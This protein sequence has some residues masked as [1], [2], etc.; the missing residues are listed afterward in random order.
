MTIITKKVRDLTLDPTSDAALLTVGLRRT[1]PRRVVLEVVRGTASHPTA[2]AVHRMARRRLPRVSLGTVY[3]N[4]RR[5][6]EEGLVQEVPGPH[7]RFD[8]NTSEH[9]H[10]TCLQCGRIV[11]VDGPLTEPHSRAL[12]SRVAAQGG[13]S[14]THHRIEF[15][16]RCAP[17]RKGSRRA[18]PASRN[19]AV[20]HPSP[21]KEKSAWQ[22]RVSRA[23][24][25]T[26]T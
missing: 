16:G 6:V 21:R 13:F 25:V 26:R 8:G 3:R 1:E 9:H 5:L 12:V 10:F 17:C 2:E 11:D 19:R 24:R 22:G 20:P 4:L 23:R 14:V 15:Y 18:R 7:A